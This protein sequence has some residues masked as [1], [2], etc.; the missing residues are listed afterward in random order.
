MKALLTS[1]GWF[2]MKLRRQGMDDPLHAASQQAMARPQA[3]IHILWHIALLYLSLRLALGP[4][5]LY[6]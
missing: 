1:C 5:T 4:L 6:V 2:P 3:V